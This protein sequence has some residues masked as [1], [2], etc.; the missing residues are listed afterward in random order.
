[1]GLH[2]EDE[3]QSWY[4]LK[5]DHDKMLKSVQE[6]TLSFVY[7]DG[8]G[9]AEGMD[10]SQYQALTSMIGEEYNHYDVANSAVKDGN[11]AMIAVF[12]DANECEL[13]FPKLNRTQKGPKKGEALEGSRR[14]LPCGGYCTYAAAVWV[15]G[16]V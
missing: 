13:L 3:V 10:V 12:C 15:G 1:M 5:A 16:M 7:N 9:G 2:L 8:D 4:M 11:S 14:L 6:G